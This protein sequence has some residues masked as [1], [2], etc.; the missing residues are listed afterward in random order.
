MEAEVHAGSQE[1]DTGGRACAQA[2]GRQQRGR[3]RLPW[4]EELSVWDKGVSESQ[5]TRAR[6]HEE[7]ESQ[8]GVKRCDH[9]CTLGRSWRLQCEGDGRVLCVGVLSGPEPAVRKA[10]DKPL[11]FNFGLLLTLLQRPHFPSLRPLP[12]AS[13]SL[14]PSPHCLCPGGRRL[15]KARGTCK[16]ERGEGEV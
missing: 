4:E 7:P 11:F 5:T 2:P 15:L 8:E 13:P 12:P 16:E 1:P 3:R 9:V 10:K 6:G 14:W